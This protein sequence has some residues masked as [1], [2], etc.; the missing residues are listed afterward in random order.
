MPVH[1][2]II[3]T[4]RVRTFPTFFASGRFTVEAEDMKVRL[5]AGDVDFLHKKAQE[6][7]IDLTHSSRLFPQKT[8]RSFG[9]QLWAKRERLQPQPLWG[10]ICSLWR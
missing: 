9:F 6:P 1:V 3:P 5:D 7:N 8:R 4:S 2:R 10:T